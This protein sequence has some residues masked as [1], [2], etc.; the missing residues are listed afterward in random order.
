MPS[1]E[2]AIVVTLGALLLG[3]AVCFTV[4]GGIGAIQLGLTALIVL[5][6]VGG[7]VLVR[8]QH[9]E[10]PQMPV[11]EAEPDETVWPPPIK[12]PGTESGGLLL[13]ES[14]SDTENKNA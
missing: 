13:S 14:I 2:R 3:T 10:P 5:C 4:V 6:F 1:K 9:Q 11:Q 7:Y 8:S 12:G